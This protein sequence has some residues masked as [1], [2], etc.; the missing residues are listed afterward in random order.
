MLA[1]SEKQ[2]RDSFVNASRRETGALPLPRGFPDLAWT[3]LDF[4]GW[5]DPRLPRRAYAVVPTDAGPVG[6]VLTT[7]A[8]GRSKSTVC[9]WCE[10][11]RETENIALYVAKRAGTAGRDGNTLGTMLH[12]DLS[13]ST[14]VRR[15]PLPHETAMAPAAFVAERVL[16]LQLRAAAFAK[17]LRDGN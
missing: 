3:E 10:D 9:I 11:V 14:H 13:C 8:S 7:E 1:L 2:V 15:A 5:T 16:D 6:F 17:R 12:A 4:L